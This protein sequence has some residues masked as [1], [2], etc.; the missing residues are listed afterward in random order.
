MDTSSISS[1]LL[2]EKV[3]SRVHFSVAT[4]LQMCSRESNLA[5]G[6]LVSVVDDNSP[7]GRWLLGRVDKTFPGRDHQVRVAV[8]KTRNGTLGKPISK[9]CLLEETV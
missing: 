4:T 6:N 8:F 5:I 9:L 2:L 1:R 7:R 3:D